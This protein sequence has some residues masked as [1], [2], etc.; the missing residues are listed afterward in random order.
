MFHL[1]QKVLK[2]PGKVL[3]FHIQLTFSNL[4]IIYFFCSE[5]LRVPV[6]EAS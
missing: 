5:K 1:V 6:A 4:T 2:N 3:E